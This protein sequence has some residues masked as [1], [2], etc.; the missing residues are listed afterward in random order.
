MNEARK[1]QS[2][3]TMA[4]GAISERVDYEVSKVL[5]NISDPNTEASKPRVIALKLTFLPDADRRTIQVK[6]E[7]QVKLQPT[8]AVQTMLGAMPDPSTGEMIIAEMTAYDPGQ[9]LLFGND[10]EPAVLRVVT[11]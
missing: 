4:R 8:T 1:A 7:A 10:E 6:A 5:D 3:L 9:K 11:A 2:I